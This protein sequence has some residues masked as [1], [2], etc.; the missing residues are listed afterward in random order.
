MPTIHSSSSQQWVTDKTYYKA[1]GGNR[2]FPMSP[3]LSPTAQSKQ[4]P[5]GWGWVRIQ[6]HVD[7]Q[8]FLF[9]RAAGMGS[10]HFSGLIHWS[11]SLG[12]PSPDCE[13]WPPASGMTP[14]CPINLAGPIH[15][16]CTSFSPRMENSQNFETS[17]APEPW[18]SITPKCRF[19]FLGYFR[20]LAYHLYHTDVLWTLS[21]IIPLRKP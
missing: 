9:S 7:N 20:S 5:G 1:T 13:T 10:C 18:T 2:S 19:F 21:G 3:A 4:G 16:H 6:E 11:S 14:P 12:Y 8:W 17:V 15:L